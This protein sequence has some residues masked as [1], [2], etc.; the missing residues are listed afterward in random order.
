[1][2]W[3]LIKKIPLQICI[4]F[5]SFKKIVICHNWQSKKHKKLRTK[6]NSQV[7]YIF[8]K[9][10]YRHHNLF[11]KINK[12][13]KSNCKYFP[14]AFSR[15][16]RDLAPFLIKKTTYLTDAIAKMCFLL[17]LNERKT[18]IKLRLSPEVWL[19]MVETEIFLKAILLPHKNI[20][21]CNYVR[22][23]KLK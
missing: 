17:L 11:K 23:N 19:F 1:M 16:K 2:M 14:K 18:V 12:Q 10:N 7:I 6:Y 13:V 9:K 15:R 8:V 20:V 21:K 22:C 4:F 5:N 3:K